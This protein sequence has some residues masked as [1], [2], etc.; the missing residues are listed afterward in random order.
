MISTVNQLRIP[1]SFSGSNKKLRKRKLTINKKN[2]WLANFINY[3]KN[4]KQQNDILLHFT[5]YYASWRTFKGFSSSDSLPSILFNLPEW[6]QMKV[7]LK[8]AAFCFLNQSGS[9][10]MLGGWTWLKMFNRKAEAL[11][12]NF[13]QGLPVHIQLPTQQSL[14]HDICLNFEVGF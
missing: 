14:R 2:K 10:C 9:R 4:L 1:N 12:L 7:L 3:L 6:L 11:S 8:L 5:V 13:F